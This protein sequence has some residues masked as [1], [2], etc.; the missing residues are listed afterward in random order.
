[1]TQQRRE[2]KEPEVDTGISEADW[3]VGEFRLKGRVR[4]ESVAYGDYINLVT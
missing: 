3:W 2:E 4:L 1:M